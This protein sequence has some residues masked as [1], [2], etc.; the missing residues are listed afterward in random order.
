MYRNKKIALLF[1]YL[2]DL[3]RELIVVTVSASQ[4]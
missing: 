3:Q 4:G 1:F 2:L